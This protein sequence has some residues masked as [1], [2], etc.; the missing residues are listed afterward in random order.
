LLQDGRAAN[1]QKAI[2]DQTAGM[3]LNGEM[4]A[5]SYLM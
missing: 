5:F 2:A 1:S 3:I 4:A